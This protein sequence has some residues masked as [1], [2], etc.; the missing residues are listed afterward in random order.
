MKVKIYKI[1]IQKKNDQNTK[2]KGQKYEVMGPH[3]KCE[4]MKHE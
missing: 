2:K 1:T 4:I 3:I